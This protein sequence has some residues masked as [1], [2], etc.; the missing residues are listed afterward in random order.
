MKNVSCFILSVALIVAHSYA[1]SAQ[2]TGLK[3]G[4]CSSYVSS[5]IWAH[6]DH[7]IDGSGF[8]ATFGAHDNVPYRMWFSDGTHDIDWIYW[9]LG[10]VYSL[11]TMQI[12]NNNYLAAGYASHSCTDVDIYVS[13]VDEPNEPEWVAVEPWEFEPIIIDEND[14]SLVA[15]PTLNPGTCTIDYDTPDVINLVGA[16]A[17][18]VLLVAKASLYGGPT[19]GLSEIRFYGEPYI[20]EMIDVSV[21]DFSSESVTSPAVNTINNSGMDNALG[22]HDSVSEN[23]WQADGDPNSN[24][25]KYPWIVW[26]LQEVRKINSVKVWNFNVGRTV[27]AAKDVDIYISVDS[28]S[29]VADWQL[30]DQV[31]LSGS[32]VGADPWGTVYTESYIL[33]NIVYLG[34]IE[35]R[36]V[37][38]QIITK[39]LAE[40][41][42][43]PAEANDGYQAGLSEVKFY[44]LQPPSYCGD[45]GTVYLS[46]DF[47]HDCYVG[48]SDLEMLASDWLSC[49]DPANPN[50]IN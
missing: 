2:I 17:R 4:N 10:G 43:G 8:D 11:D 21:V 15:S 26:D 32:G 30:V 38:F 9:D 46:L 19:K 39:W 48:V 31:T 13:M 5:W 37:K 23:M 20:E 7:L 1:D 22:A 41:Q 44:E 50:C 49:N 45:V 35:A 24:E 29:S 16:K 34:D 18:H 3:T 28:D 36:L 14:W 12:W 25:G 47:D 42:D 33:P 40:T 6:P 27:D